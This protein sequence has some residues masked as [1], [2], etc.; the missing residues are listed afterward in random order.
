MHYGAFLQEKKSLLFPKRRILSQL[1][2]VITFF[3]D[4]F[5]CGDNPDQ[6][7]RVITLKYLLFF[8]G[9]IIFFNMLY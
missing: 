1:S 7:C 2:F 9:L 6:P 3:Y 5:F 4:G 8:T